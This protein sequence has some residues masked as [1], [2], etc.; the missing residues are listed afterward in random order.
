M[1]EGEG[2]AVYSAV[3]VVAAEGVVEA[4]VVVVVVAVVVD[5]LS[6]SVKH[7]CYWGSVN[8]LLAY[9]YT[10]EAVPAGSYG[11]SKREISCH[12]LQRATCESHDHQ[13]DCCFK[14][15]GAVIVCGQGVH[16]VGG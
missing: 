4:E 11:M 1:G 10:E 15:L 6:L 9:V 2:G 7:V 16:S 3:V 14:L 13:F 12:C 8:G 5:K